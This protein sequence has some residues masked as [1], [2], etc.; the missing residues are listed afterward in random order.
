[1][2]SS[3]LPIEPRLFVSLPPFS[4]IYWSSRQF[5]IVSDIRLGP[6]II[7]RGGLRTYLARFLEQLDQ[8]TRYCAHISGLQ[9]SQAKRAN[10]GA[11]YWQRLSTLILDYR[12]LPKARKAARVAMYSFLSASLDS[13]KTTKR[14]IYTAVRLILLWMV[15]I[16]RGCWHFV[17]RLTRR[18]TLRLAEISAYYIISSKKHFLCQSLCPKFELFL[19]HLPIYMDESAQKIKTDYRYVY[20]KSLNGPYVFIFGRYL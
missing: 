15:R 17:T 7:S 12:R 16:L 1:M 20:I 4:C 19:D 14:T 2:S 8:T 5:F 11:T 6:V 3:S 18:S 10:H 13:K 9:E